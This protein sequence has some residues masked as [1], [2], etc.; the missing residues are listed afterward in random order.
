MVLLKAAKDRHA[1]WSSARHGTLAPAQQ[2]K[3]WAIDWVMDKYG[4]K[5]NFKRP[6]EDICKAVTKVG[7]G[8]P[9][10]EVV[11]KLFAL[12]HWTPLLQNL[13]LAI[14]VI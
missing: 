7:G 13:V 4:E 2:A 6:Q 14:I 10:R 11:S 9:G 5:Y 1:M 8:H 3:L 12:P